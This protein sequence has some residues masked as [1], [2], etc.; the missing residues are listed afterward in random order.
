M[1]QRETA[2]IIAKMSGE[3]PDKFA[4]QTDQMMKITLN[5]W[6]EALG[7]LP[8]RLVEAAVVQYMRTE[9]RYPHPADLRKIIV[10]HDTKK[11]LPNPQE[12]WALVS[13]AIRNGNYGA[14]EEFAKLPPAVQKAV[15]DPS[16]IRKWAAMDSGVVHS[17]EASNFQ[18][19]YQVVLNR[20]DKERLLP[21]E[22]RS[23]MAEI[24]AEKAGT[25][26]IEDHTVDDVKFAQPSRENVRRLI[27]SVRRKTSPVGG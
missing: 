1:N 18:R 6:Y 21:P 4:H 3:W 27:D 23:Y 17:V 13:K 16:Q 12:A 15:G 11:D 9:S 10:S 26:A 24:D 14:E 7:D 5:N 22:E 2:A 8:Y 20:I 25:P 19:T